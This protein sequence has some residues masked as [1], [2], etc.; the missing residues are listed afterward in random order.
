ML[1]FLEN[2]MDLYVMAAIFAFGAVGKIVAAYTYKRLMKQCSKLSWEK[3]GYLKHIK[4]KYETMHRAN[5]GVKNCNVFLENQM[6]R[7]RILRIPIQKWESVAIHAALFCFFS[8]VGTSF[9]CFWYSL[10]VRPIV[11]HFVLGVLF[12]VALIMI[13][14]IADT[15]MKKDMLIVFLQDY[16]ENNVSAQIERTEQ[17]T[18]IRSVTQKN[19]MKDDIFMQKKEKMESVKNNE[20]IKRDMEQIAAT[21]EPIEERERRKLTQ[22]EEKLLEDIIKEYLN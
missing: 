13:D 2:G 11:L 10:G 7:Y 22:E 20:A 6:N 1:Q 5:D 4:N 16:L 3:E 19:R 18:E 12:G 14:G 15:A 8:G 9:L 17:Q 21:R